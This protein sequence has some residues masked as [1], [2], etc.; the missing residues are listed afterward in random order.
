[1][2]LYAASRRASHALLHLVYRKIYRC[3]MEQAYGQLLEGDVD[4]F[5]HG[6][7]TRL[8]VFHFRNFRVPTISSATSGVDQQQEFCYAHA[9]L[10]PFES[11]I[12]FQ[13]LRHRSPARG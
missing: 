9:E 10:N 13:G 2:C 11:P 3:L 6:G 7:R 4:F 1:M 5:R 8:Y 12:T